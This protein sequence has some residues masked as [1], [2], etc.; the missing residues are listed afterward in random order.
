MTAGAAITA[1]AAPA[2]VPAPVAGA[3][4]S[5]TPAFEAILM[6]QN[7]AAPAEGV[8]TTEL[9]AGED[10]GDEDD[11]GEELEASLAFLS[12]LLTATTPKDSPGDS[13]AGRQQGGTSPE[14]LPG[15]AAASK[16]AG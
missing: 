4:A 12:A 5:T 10:S 6:L 15:A 7:L 14:D 16:A 13:S 8:D 2:A 11:T 1:E 3:A 9:V